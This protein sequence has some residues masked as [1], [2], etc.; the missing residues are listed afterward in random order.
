MA[1]FA[2]VVPGAMSCT[3]LALALALFLDALDAVVVAV[4]MVAAEVVDADM[5][6]ASSSI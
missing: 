5:S 1:A 4:E 3:R 2:G 6:A